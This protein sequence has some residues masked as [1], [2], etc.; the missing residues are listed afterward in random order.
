MIKKPS[1]HELTTVGLLSYWADKLLKKYE[2]QIGI[3]KQYDV[4]MFCD[5]V[6]PGKAYKIMYNPDNIYHWDIHNLIS[7]VFHEI[8]H[9]KSEWDSKVYGE[10]QGIVDEYIAERYS[11]D[12]MKKYYPDSIPFVIEHTKSLFKDKLLEPQ[13]KNHYIAF[14]Q[15]EEYQ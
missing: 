10:A 15:I 14:K 12:M 7:G 13:Y 1:G 2:I 5:E 8:G 6:I 11:L 4:H 9:I 3:S